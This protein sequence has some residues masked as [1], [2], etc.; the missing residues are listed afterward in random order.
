M[1]ESA[2]KNVWDL[3]A[4]VRQRL[5][6]GAASVTFAWS[7]PP[8]STSTMR[9]WAVDDQGVAY[10]LADDF[11]A[12]RQACIDARISHSLRA[13]PG[14]PATLTFGYNLPLLVPPAGALVLDLRGHDVTIE[15]RFNPDDPDTPSLFIGATPK[16]PDDD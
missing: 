14:E 16:D 15:K 1:A 3:L 10:D 2:A 4:L 12:L 13:Y 5:D 7:C 11:M 9:T 8:H 6:A